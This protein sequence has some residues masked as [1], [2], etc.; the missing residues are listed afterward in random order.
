MDFSRFL[1]PSLTS[2]NCE[3]PRSFFVP[4]ST[5]EAAM[6]G[7]FRE[8]DR[9][10]SLDGDWMF[11]YYDTML[12]VPDN[13][14]NVDFDSHIPVPAC[15][16][17]HGYGQLWYTNINYQIPYTAPKV[18]VDTP[19]GIYKKKFEMHPGDKRVYIV[20]EGVNSMYLVYLNGVYIG[21][22]KGAHLQHE[23][24][25]TGGIEEGENELIVVVTT[26]S[27]A[28]YIED[29]DFLRFNGI[30]RD[31]YLLERDENHIEDFFIRTDPSGIVSVDIDFSGMC[32]EPELSIYDADTRIEGMRVNEPTLWNAENPYLYKLVIKCGTEYIG[33]S[34]GFAQVTIEDSV[35]K[36]NG[37]P[38]KIKGVNHHDT[39]PET[40]WY[41]T[42]EDMINDLRL[43]KQ[44]NINAI[45]FSHYPPAPQMIEM[46]DKFGFY[47]IDEC[48]LEAHGLERVFKGQDKFNALSGNPSWREAYLDRMKRT[49][50][51]DKNGT[52]IIMWSLGNESFFGENHR[53]MS[54]YVKNRDKRP[55]HY[56]GTTS[57]R[58]I[59]PAE[60]RPSIEECD[61][62]VDVIS[63]MYWGIDGMEAAGINEKG[64]TRPFFLCEYG[65]AMGMGPGSLEEYWNVIYRYPRLCGGCVWEWADHAVYDKNKNAYLYGG[66]FGDQPND[67]NFCV[68]GLN[69]PD[70]RPHLG[71]RSL[72]KAIQPLRFSFCDNVLTIT[73]TMDF[74]HSDIF[75]IGY[76]FVSGGKEL[77]RGLIPTDIHPHESVSFVLNDYPETAQ[78]RVF[79]EVNA[80][81]RTTNWYAKAGDTVAWAQFEVDTEVEKAPK[82]DHSFES[83][84]VEDSDRYISVRAAGITYVF[85][86]A[87]GVLISAI[88]N[89]RDLLAA[90]SE[91]IFR[92]AP[93]DNDRNE[94]SY[95]QDYHTDIARLHVTSVSTEIHDNY[96]K[97]CVDG[98][99]A[100]KSKLPYYIV[101]IEYVFSCN[102][103]NVSVNGI[104]P[105][106]ANFMSIPR[107]ALMFPLCEGFE[108]LEYFGMGPYS[109]YSDFCNHTK[110]GYFTS[111][112]TDEFEPMIKPQ[113]CGNHIG[114]EFAEVFSKDASVR[115]DGEFE[116]SALHHSPDELTEKQHV[117]EL[118]NDGKTYL[119]VGYKQNGVGSNSCGPRPLDC[120]I[121]KDKIIQ[122]EVNVVFK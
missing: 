34:F 27:D 12:E 19:V 2:E 47:V 41:M 8:S 56:E 50:E 55:I 26:Y 111:T 63:T 5:R 51:R 115:V 120:Y 99:F 74:L 6:S 36:V 53:K 43:M 76:S 40:G 35:L 105:D 33:K 39:N 83:V 85:D 71:L 25:L 84:L 49:F 118:S 108:K 42:D 117:H 9:Y 38:I 100:A 46:C 17:N 87:K 80:V 113:E 7:N 104:M 10:I 94:K 67:G 95:W 102:G 59:I 65:H 97:L 73:N 16:Q 23:F 82:P 52:S 121:F 24:E 61:P 72:K 88:K 112:V 29:Q 78:D 70:R 110:F 69:Y 1:V 60:V 58:T 20:F 75:D 30:F 68:D 14:V 101:S 28:T 11:H 54:E 22:A 116:F 13:L 98:A 45:R 96:A 109:C 114:C 57:P 62:C 107:V 119:I 122:F 89:G 48:D 21:M 86:K 81:Y 18:P 44:N 90:P 3:Q 32:E 15:W 64:H 106:K 77:F 79:L 31:V 91:W 66:D 103:M 93:M 92:R 37:K 4:F